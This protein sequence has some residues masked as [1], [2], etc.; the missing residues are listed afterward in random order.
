MLFD[1]LL[2]FKLNIYVMRFFI[3][4]MKIKYPT[5]KI[6]QNK[7][8]EQKTNIILSVTAYIFLFSEV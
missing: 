8:T 3:G 5:I 2:Y 1:L 7:I 6:T 4:L